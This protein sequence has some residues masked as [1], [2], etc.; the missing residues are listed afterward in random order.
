MK[1]LL[2]ATADYLDLCTQKA[3]LA[4]GDVF[5]DMDGDFHLVQYVNSSGAYA[6]PLS[7]IT[8]SIGG[9]EIGFTAGGRTLSVYSVVHVVPPL[10]MGGN[11]PEYKRYVTMVQR[12]GKAGT[13][14][15]DKFKGVT[16]ERFDE[17]ALPDGHIGDGDEETVS[18]EGDSDM[19]KTKK[20][21]A[22]A[23]RVKPTKTVRACAC[24]CGG[25]TTGYFNPGHDAKLHGWVKKLADGRIQ[26]N[27]KDAKSGEQIVPASVL[28][29]LKLV[30]KGD[31]FKAT[32]EHFYKD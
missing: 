5:R 16:Y 26:K 21:A 20:K 24:G 30:A 31:G 19:A 9:K 14:P 25:E 8:R 4:Q 28:N 17:T 10:A 27:G 12:S 6:V 15:S 3:P 7:A 23:K 32:A 1:P 22:K 18:S 29:K 2:K 13:L 11:S